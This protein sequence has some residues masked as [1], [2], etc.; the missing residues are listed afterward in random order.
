MS[1][2]VSN[3]SMSVADLE[4]CLECPICLEVPKCA[5][6][7]QCSNGHIL[8]NKCK[9]KITV[10]PFCRKPMRTQRN[11]LA[12]KLLEKLP[13]KCE[14]VANGC[15]KRML[16]TVLPGHMTTCAH[17]DVQCFECKDKHPMSALGDHLKTSHFFRRLGSVEKKATVL[18]IFTEEQFQKSCSFGPVLLPFEGK[19]FFLMLRN[20]H[21]ESTSFQIWVYSCQ[22]KDDLKNT[23]SRIQFSGSETLT[24]EGPVISAEVKPLEVRQKGLGLIF[25]S[26]YAKRTLVNDKLWVVIEIFD[27]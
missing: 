15:S 25:S 9:T 17:R 8:C 16:S 21:P 23:R 3:D 10:C 26:E 6:I 19:D 13:V 2:T 14:F 5:P 24:Y 18:Y 1:E 27:I 11:L 20:V 12:E 7:Y 4:E 22:F